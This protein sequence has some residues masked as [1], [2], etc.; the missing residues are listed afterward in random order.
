M[1]EKKH[2]RSSGHG[3]MLTENKKGKKNTLPIT[4]YTFAFF[5]FHPLNGTDFPTSDDGDDGAQR[6][7]LC[8]EI[9]MG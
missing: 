6:S 2:V 5:P 7:T 8:E 4:A 3:E 1:V 9:H